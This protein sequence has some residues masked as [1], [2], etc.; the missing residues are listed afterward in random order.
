[1]QDMS[2]HGIYGMFHESGGWSIESEFARQLDANNE[3]HGIQQP[4]NLM[5]SEVRI[6]DLV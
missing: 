5:K 2:Q 1:M 3:R 6:L 4:D